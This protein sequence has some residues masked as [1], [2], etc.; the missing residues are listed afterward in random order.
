MKRIVIAAAGLLLAGCAASGT[1]PPA[2]TAGTVPTT[3]TISGATDPGSGGI[4]G[5]STS[6][7]SYR[8]ATGAVHTLPLPPERVWEVLPQVYESLGIPVTTSVPATRTIGNPAVQ[9]SRTLAG[10]RGSQL[11]D[12]GQGP[13]GPLAD[14]YRVDLSVLTLLEPAPGGGTRVENR[15]NA[16]A[17]NRGASGAPVTCGS[18]GALEA[19]VIQKIQELARS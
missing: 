16:T 19:Q 12:C 6:I 8:S 17:T 9:F 11:L 1:T 18:T 5:L 4:G 7:E 13:L 14:S 15:V 2:G 3:T 10:K